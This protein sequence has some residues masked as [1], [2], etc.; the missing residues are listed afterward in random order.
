MINYIIIATIVLVVGSAAAYIIKSKR[1]GKKCIGCPDCTA[2]S[3][4]ACAGCLGRC[5]KN[6][7]E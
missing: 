1:S 5:Q 6:K 2:C 3:Q 4:N 7:S